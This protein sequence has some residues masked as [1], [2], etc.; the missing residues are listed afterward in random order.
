MR[1][2]QVNSK[3]Y[4]NSLCL[5]VKNVFYFMKYALIRLR[6][7]ETSEYSF[8]TIRL[9]EIFIFQLTIPDLI[10]SPSSK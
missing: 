9:S 1:E 3:K 7:L 5:C 6:V 10:S 4:Q 2:N 8:F